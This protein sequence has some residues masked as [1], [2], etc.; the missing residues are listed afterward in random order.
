MNLRASCASAFC[1]LFLASFAEVQARGYW[2]PPLVPLQPESQEEC[3]RLSREYQRVLNELNQ[4]RSN[5]PTVSWKGEVFSTPA[6]NHLDA[7]VSYSGAYTACSA[8]IRNTICQVNV[9]RTAAVDRCRA[10]VREYQARKRREQERRDKLEDANDKNE[11]L[12]RDIADKWMGEAS[13]AAQKAA[14]GTEWEKYQRTYDDANGKV[15]TLKDAVALA[16]L[17]AGEKTAEQAIKDWADGLK[18]DPTGGLSQSIVSG[19]KNPLS[20]FL[21]DIARLVT[22]RKANQYMAELDSA[23]EGFSALPKKPAPMTSR[24]LAPA[25]PTPSK[26]GFAGGCLESSGSWV[27]NSCG[28]SIRVQAFDKRSL[29]PIYW[30]WNT[31]SI[32]GESPAKYE[33]A[34]SG[35]PGSRVTTGALVSDNNDFSGARKESI[36]IA[37]DYNNGKENSCVEAVECLFGKSNDMINAFNNASDYEREKMDGAAQEAAIACGVP[38]THIKT[39]D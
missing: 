36:F 33:P 37:C 26:S 5:C 12:L 27:S 23:F 3:S 34:I 22:V 38:E 32:W 31:Q 39:F 29:G 21:S 24:V 18:N 15:R 9:S 20:S 25:K 35:A 19:M 13:N 16:K 1:V 8:P 17:A 11:D 7:G 28:T 6:C 14:K 10:N 30:M 2:V 4:E